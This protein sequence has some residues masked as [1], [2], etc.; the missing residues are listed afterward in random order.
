MIQRIQSLYLLAATSLLTVLFRNPVSRIS[1]SDNLIMEMNA[2]KI[3]AI[4]GS[5]VDSVFVWPYTVLLALVIIIGLGSIF[6]YKNRTLQMRLCMYNMFLML[7]LI[8]LIWY[9]TKFTFNELEGRQV[10]YLWPVV[11]PFISA[12]FTYLAFKK[13]QRDDALIKSYDRIR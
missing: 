13:I 6:A 11:I 2:F 1:I 4:T 12:I 3:E 9:F 7:G 10:L 8:G 5:T